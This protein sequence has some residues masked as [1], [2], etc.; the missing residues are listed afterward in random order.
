[1]GGSGPSISAEHSGDLLFTLSAVEA[2]QLESSGLS[3]GHFGDRDVAVGGGC[4]HGQMGD[5]KDLAL[6]GKL[7]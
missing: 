7:S 4:D 2:D 5:A 3:V 6:A 1:M